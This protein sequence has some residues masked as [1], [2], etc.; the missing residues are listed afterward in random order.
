MR[1]HRPSRTY[2]RYGFH[3]DDGDNTEPRDVVCPGRRDIQAEPELWAE[4]KRS[5]RTR[6]KTTVVSG[7]V[8]YGRSPCVVSGEVGNLKFDALSI[9]HLMPDGTQN[10]KGKRTITVSF[11]P[12][13]PESV[14]DDHPVHEPQDPQ[15]DRV[16][17]ALAESRARVR[18]LVEREHEGEHVSADVMNLRFRDAQ[19]PAARVCAETG[20]HDWDPVG[21]GRRPCRRCG[22]PGPV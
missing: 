14:S 21:I 15:F 22:L 1:R 8:M 10:L 18:P 9:Y 7:L 19:P 20:Q 12:D 13:A 3:P 11:E 17:R 2:R 4:I 5:W 6:S 16:A